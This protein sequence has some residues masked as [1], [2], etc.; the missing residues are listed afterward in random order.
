MTRAEKIAK[1]CE[2]KEAIGCLIEECESLNPTADATDPDWIV[3]DI[4]EITGCVLTAALVTMCVRIKNA[5]E[6]FSRAEAA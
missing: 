4:A 2:I 6:E 5:E 3:D 1:L